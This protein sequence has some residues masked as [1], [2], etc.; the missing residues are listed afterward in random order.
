MGCVF[1]VDYACVVSVQGPGLNRTTLRPAVCPQA[2]LP[3]FGEVGQRHVLLLAEPCGRPAAAGQRLHVH[4][5]FPVE[6]VHKGQN[7]QVE[8]RRGQEQTVPRTRT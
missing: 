8:A 3:Q 4:V 7:L 2:C 5:V 6:L 1:G